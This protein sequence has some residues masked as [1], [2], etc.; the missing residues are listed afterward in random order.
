M[1]SKQL[2]A[3]GLLVLYALIMGVTSLVL[4][5]ATRQLPVFGF[6]SFRF[7]FAFLACLLLFRKRSIQELSPRVIRHA[8]LVGLV[9]FGAHVGCTA[10]MAVT[11]VGIA[12]FLTSLQT[13]IIPIISFFVLKQSFD[14]RTLFCI[15]GTFVSV[16]LITA[17][18]FTGYSAGIW[19]CIGS[20]VLAAGQILLIEWC[21]NAG[22]DVVALTVWQLGVMALCAWLCALCTGSVAV[23]E[24]NVSWLCIGWTALVSTALATY[25]QTYAQQ[26]TS[27]VHT[28]II[29]SSIPIF[30]LIGSRIVFQEHFGLRAAFGAVLLIGCIVCMELRPVGCREKAKEV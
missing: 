8:V 23:P 16:F 28:G 4:K 30:T 19:L 15:F 21:V 18:N 1:L 9:T 27:S 11:P 6:L 17:G 26:Y 20:S 29:F 2:K 13:I 7:G 25:I 12:G 5:I 10:G 22:D 24:N 14:K 3:D